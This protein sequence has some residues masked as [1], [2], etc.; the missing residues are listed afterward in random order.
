[1]NEASLWR[2]EIARYVAPIIAQN[3]KVKA[4]VLAGSVSRGNADSYS[5]IEINVIWS[6]PPTEEDRMSPIVPAGGVFWELDPYDP[7][8]LTWMDEWGLGGVKMDMRN[9]TEDGLEQI[10]RAVT[11]QADTAEFKQMT[12]SA[13]QHGI[14]LHNPK[15]LK[16]CQTQIA[17]YPHDLRLAMIRENLQLEA[18]CWWVEMLA[19]RGD[20]PL[21]YSA[22]SE[23]TQKI[24]LLHMGLNGIYHPGMK[25]MNRLI[26]EMTITPPNLS[27]RIQQA[28]QAA[29]HLAFA[30]LRDLMIE[31]YDLVD[32]HMPEVV[33]T[34]AR[35]AFL[36][37]RPQIMDMPTHIRPVK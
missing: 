35:S 20:L 25:W 21:V 36:Q 31:T 8:E 5:D 7:I 9:R 1:M 17:V 4:I 23:V 10:I 27:T 28:F 3:P 13:F 12:V 15:W 30:I 2:L 16:K 26:N 24:L 22:F 29:P 32:L 14:S 37:Q 18:W 19:T 33:T 34:D 6:K 11:D